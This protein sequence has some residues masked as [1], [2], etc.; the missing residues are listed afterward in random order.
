MG[1]VT[2]N[3]VVSIFLWH[4]P[5]LNGNL[6]GFSELFQSPYDV[7]LVE[8]EVKLLL[9]PYLKILSGLMIEKGLMV[10]ITARKSSAG[11]WGIESSCAE[12]DKWPAPLHTAAGDSTSLCRA[13]SLP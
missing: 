8:R 11:S 6:R 3:F 10:A 13:T 12:V 5:S 1:P 2:E 4:V 7:P 9:F